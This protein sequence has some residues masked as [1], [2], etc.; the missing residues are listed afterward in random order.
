MA[1]YTG[2]FDES[3]SEAG[4]FFVF[5][6][7]VLDV[8]AKQ[9]F[10]REWKAAIQ[11]LPMLHTSPFLAGGKGFEHWNSNGLTWK[12]EL[13]KKAACVVEKHALWTFAIALDMDSFRDLSAR[14]N[15][16]EF[17]AYPYALCARYSAV[18]VH[19]HWSERNGIPERVKLVFEDR[20]KE[21]VKEVVRVFSRDQL[22]IPSFE[23]KTVLPLQAADLIAVIHARKIMRKP[24]FSQVEPVYGELNQMLHSTEYL[25]KDL[26]RFAVADYHSTHAGR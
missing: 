2:Y 15:F 17:V 19:R 10:E 6:G 21:D 12:Q 20:S 22:D 1:F 24:S 25:G 11:P 4:P 14:E 9:E 3:E 5:G 8:E 18:L 23:D 16:D 13:L 26:E 7:L